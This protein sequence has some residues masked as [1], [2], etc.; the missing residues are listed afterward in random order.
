[1]QTPDS[2]GTKSLALL[3]LAHTLEKYPN[4]EQ[5]VAYLREEAAKQQ[6]ALRLLEAIHAKTD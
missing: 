5:A 4:T 3:R 6:A 2:L 1:M